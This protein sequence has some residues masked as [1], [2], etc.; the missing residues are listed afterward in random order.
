MLSVVEVYTHRILNRHA[1]S[2]IYPCRLKKRPRDCFPMP[3]RCRQH[4]AELQTNCPRPRIEV[5]PT[6]AQKPTALPSL[7]TLT[8][9]LNV[10]L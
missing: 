1:L 6:R 3:A 4:C 9:T 5:K 10:D 2:H 8:L 7:L